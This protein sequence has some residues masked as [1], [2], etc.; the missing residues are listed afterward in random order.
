L[1][2]AKRHTSPPARHV[3]AVASGK[4]GVGKSTIALNLALAL[5]DRGL[6]VGLLDADV[7]GPNIPPMVNLTRT[8]PLARWALWR[9]G[10]LGLEPVE[11]HGVKLMSAG[12]LLGEEQAFPWSAQTVEWVLRQLVYDVDWGVLDVLLVDLPPGTADLQQELVRTVPLAGALVVVGPQDVAHLDARK[13]VAMLRENDVRILGG[14]ENM[15]AF[16]CPHCG[17]PIEV[18]PTVREDRSLWA[19]G[20]ERLAAIPLDPALAHAAEQGR[21]LLAGDRKGATADAFRTLA[22][23]LA[24][25]LELLP[26]AKGL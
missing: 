12:F 22:A 5:R 18:F 21:P 4:G 26:E 1:P 25:L 16:A 10:G 7:F 6:A 9:E 19:A 11:R 13:L 3:V 8:Q 23:T 20:V 24:G 15:T 17:E 14:V 2:E